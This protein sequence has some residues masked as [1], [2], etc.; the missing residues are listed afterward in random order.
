MSDLSVGNKFV[1]LV[2]GTATSGKSTSLMN[3]P[4]PENIAYFNTDL[5]EIPFK[6]KM[7]AVGITSP[8]QLLGGITAIETIP[9][10]HT[11]CVDTITHL[12]AQFETQHIQTAVDTQKAWG[13]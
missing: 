11:A 1:I 12:I 7:R 2:T 5:K 3:M 8:G 4:Q 9:A 10:I 6:H 13:N